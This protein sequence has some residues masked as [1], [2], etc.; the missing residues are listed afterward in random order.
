MNSATNVVDMLLETEF[1]RVCMYCEKERPVAVG[2]GQSKSHGLCR[3][4]APDYIRDTTQ[5]IPPEKQ[6]QMIATIS[7]KP[8][9]AFAPDSSQST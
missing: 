4:H 7:G 2:V 1:I 6:E 5:G 8:D 3:R 9:S